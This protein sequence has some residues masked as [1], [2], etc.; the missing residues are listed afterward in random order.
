M[1]VLV[2]YDSKF[3]NTERIARTIANVL[4]ERASVRLISAGEGPLDV[5]GIDVMVVGGPTHAHGISAALRAALDAV[6]REALKG[7]NAAAFDTRFQL[8]RFLVGGAAI[9]VARRLRRRGAELVVSPQS[10]FVAKTE[11]PLLD[12]ELE[13]AAAWAT[14]LL[15]RAG[16]PGGVPM[17]VVG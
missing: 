6:P 14:L 4:A 16:A 8:P 7:I 17:P 12:G 15:D 5:E 3:G 11:G 1:Q 13:R 2:V 9:H 10:F